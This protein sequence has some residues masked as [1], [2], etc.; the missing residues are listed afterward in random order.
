MSD[1]F[2]PSQA[3]DEAIEGLIRLA[4]EENFPLPDATEHAALN[5]S[6]KAMQSGGR[7][8]NVVAIRALLWLKNYWP[9]LEDGKVALSE[10]TENGIAVPSDDICSI[11][12][13]QATTLPE[14]N[15]GVDFQPA[16]PPL[17]ANKPD[18]Q[19]VHYDDPAADVVSE[20]S[21][22]S[23]VAN[24]LDALHHHYQV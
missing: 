2:K 8:R 15:V 20:K 17:L 5:Q 18:D 22:Q 21:S 10:E 9:A 4:E 12:S 24:V 7:T 23:E 19:S 13:D 14:D 3:L 1:A 16:V 11:S 6:F